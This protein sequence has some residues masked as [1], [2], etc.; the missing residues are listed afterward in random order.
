MIALAL[1]FSTAS[2]MAEDV[3]RIRLNAD[4]RSLD[5]GVNRDANTDIVQSHLFEG[6]VAYTE[7]A[8]IDPLVAKSVHVSSDGKAYTFVLRDGLKFSNGE[9]VTTHDVLFSW[10]R[11]TDPVT[12]WRCL[13]EVD[14]RGAVKVTDVSAKDDTTVVFTLEKPSALFLTTLARTDCGGTGIFHRSSIGADGRWKEPITTAPFKLREW[15]RNQ[16]I[17]LVKNENYMPLPG[18]PDGMTGNKSVEVDKARF[19]IIPDESTAK[20]ALIAGDLDINYDVENSDLPEYKT[21]KD[22]VLDTTPIMNVGDF[23]FQTNDP[24]LK[25][26]RIRKAFLLSLD[27]PELVN[28]VTDGQATPSN[29]PIPKPSIFYGPVQKELVQRDVEAAKKLLSEAGYNGQPIKMLTNKRY[30]TMFNSAIAAQAMA[31]ETGLNIELEVVDWGAQTDRYLSGDYQIMSHGFSAR[32]DPSL[33]FDMFSG[34]KKEE[35]R[36]VWENE[37]ALQLLNKSM[38]ASDPKERQTLL[39]QIEKLFRE[40]VAMIVTHSGVRTSAVRSNVVGYKGWALGTPRAWGVQL[41]K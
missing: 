20:A 4:I 9:P 38:V 37:K 8:S 32:L 19:A 36:K 15:K 26:V 31:A 2:A 40:D 12:G 7:D 10:K 33:S 16:Y 28:A 6:L 3:L 25:D 27:M 22:I 23:L 35:P 41:K 29:S 21:H 11:Y 17:E 39:D 5:P 14:G 18:R 24:V 1:S 34:V 13:P 30:P